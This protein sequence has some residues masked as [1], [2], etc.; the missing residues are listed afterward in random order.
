MRE[1]RLLLIRHAETSTPNLFHGAESDIDLSAWGERQAEL[2]AEHLKAEGVDR[3]YCS[4]MRR[5][6]A[7][8]RP[9]GEALGLEPVVVP[10]LHER[11]IG[12]LSGLSRE[13]GWSVYEESKRRWIA[14]D[15][16]F[17]HAGGESF[18]DIQRRVAPIL[19]DLRQRGPG[20]T[21]AVIAHG[22]VIRVA[23]VSLLPDLSPADFDRVAIDFASINVLVHDGAAWR[24]R[25]LN[26]VVAPSDARPVA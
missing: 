22:I 17:T 4:G 19:D 18:A 13:A 7:T 12:P 2:L 15:L 21:S 23:L 11:R 24:A 5:A 10:E 16:D 3:L 1:T 9:I 8:A 25:T 20:E 14:G 6:R 26:Q